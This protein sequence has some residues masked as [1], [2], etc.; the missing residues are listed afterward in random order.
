MLSLERA[1]LLRW[2]SAALTLSLCAVV[3][4]GPLAAPARADAGP[5]PDPCQLPVAGNVCDAVTGG[6]WQ[7]LTNFINGP[8]DARVTVKDAAGGPLRVYRVR[9][10]AGKP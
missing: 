7:T 3:L 6:A 8:V 2:L 1:P 9:V 4:A 10:D 5:I